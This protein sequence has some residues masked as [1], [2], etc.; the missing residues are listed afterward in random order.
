MYGLVSE[1]INKNSRGAFNYWDDFSSL[2]YLHS[3]QIFGILKTRILTLTRLGSFWGDVI[4]DRTFEYHLKNA[5]SPNVGKSQSFN[6]VALVISL[7]H[8][9]GCFSF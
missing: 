6:S 4:F 3:F 7:Q 8:K 5:K 2:C 1:V 9:K